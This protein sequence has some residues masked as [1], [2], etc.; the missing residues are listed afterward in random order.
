[1]KMHTEVGALLNK[2]KCSEV[3]WAATV[4]VQSGKTEETK[5]AMESYQGC[6]MEIT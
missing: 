4:L 5:M 3:G 6:V 2:E 1:M